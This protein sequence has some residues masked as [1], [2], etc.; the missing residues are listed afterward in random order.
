MS[1]HG[2]GT[3]GANT[4]CQRRYPKAREARTPRPQV[5]ATHSLAAP[6]A[7]HKPALACRSAQVNARY[8]GW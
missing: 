2:A 5:P 1:P 7:G 3:R 4:V 8:M 6:T